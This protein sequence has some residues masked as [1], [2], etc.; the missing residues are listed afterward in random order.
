M[1]E[2]GVIFDGMRVPLPAGV[3]EAAVASGQFR[4]HVVVAPI[5]LGIVNGQYSVPV[6]CRVDADRRVTSTTMWIDLPVI[7][8]TPKFSIG[9]AP[10][11]YVIVAAPGS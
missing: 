4:A 5:A 11:Q 8:A 9:P 7:N 6:D 10:C 1:T 2:S 3:T